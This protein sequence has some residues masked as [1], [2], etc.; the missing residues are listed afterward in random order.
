MKKFPGGGGVRSVPVQEIRRL[1]S[2]GQKGEQA[3]YEVAVSSE[4]EV[5]RQG[6][7]GRWREVLGHDP[8]EVD[9]GRFQSGRAAVLE[10]HRGPPIGVIESARID[11]DR[12]LRA[13]IRFSRST[14][15]QEVEQDITDEIRQNI[16]I[17]YIPKRAKLI[18]ENE[19]LGD[20]WRVTLWEPVELSVVG[21]PA[22]AT[23]GVGRDVTPGNY[24]IV[25][26]EDGVAVRE[27]DMSDKVTA[28]PG[29][30]DER[31]EVE[32]IY[33][34]AEMNAMPKSRAAA[35]IEAGLTS[36]QVKRV[37]TNERETVGLS[38]PPSHPLD[39]A[40]R[41]G[42]GLLD[43][44]SLR[45]RGRYSISRAIALDAGLRDP[46]LGVKFDGLE[47]EVHRHLEKR[48][49]AE[50]RSQRGG[51]LVPTDMR[52]S[53]Q[54]WSERTL[55]G[56]LAGKGAEIVPSQ[57]GEFIE[58]LRSAAMVV[59]LGARVLPGLSAPVSFAKQVGA[60]TAVWTGEAPGA[61]IADSDMTLGLVLMPGKTLMSST[62]FS[63]QLLIQGLPEVDQLIK[64]DIVEV[65]TRAID[66]A[67]IHGLGAAGQPLGIYNSPGV[68][69]IAMGGAVSFG[70]LID[71][72]TEVANDNAASGALG[73]LMTVALAG[74]LKQ[75]LVAASAGSDMIWTGSF[76]DGRIAG[77]R[78]AA[79][80]Q[81]SSTM[82]GSSETG[83]TEHGIIFGNWAEVII[84]L[85]SVLELITDPFSKKKRGIIEVTSFQ[86]ADVI[87]RHGESFCKATG[88]T[89]A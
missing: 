25:E 22:D 18:E 14:R 45:D 34:L 9:L 5:E 17:G 60:T 46:S 40:E 65:H 53:E 26:I 50:F 19:E 39:A 82:S 73:Y 52:T 63:R 13:E 30:R 56:N 75:T 67:C 87:L 12:V 6:F 10:E 16:S 41:M 58:M 85:F 11:T 51:I 62:G 35:W 84:G 88:A 7:F 15:G 89:L 43:G 71:M 66:K 74:K 28:E 80:S 33:A 72:V 31:R 49:P 79:S 48:L 81:V 59:R 47:A 77:F 24:P 54:R 2:R 42:G 61:D 27:R 57:T 3:R 76:E 37:I 1:E 78:A 68:N 36:E 38:R 55:Q 20:L 21:I 29:A 69:A 4:S 23:V 32:T 83:G 64:S 86:M 8:D 70:E 44:L